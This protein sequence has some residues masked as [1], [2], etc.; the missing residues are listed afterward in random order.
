MKNIGL[1][2]V[3]GAISLSVCLASACS[4]QKSFY[5]Q[6]SG[7]DYLRFPLLEPYYAIYVTNEY[8][9]SI[10]LHGKPTTRNF[11]YYLNIQDVRKIAVEN[12]VIMIYTPYT[13]QIDL[14]D[15]QKRELHWFI[16][17][18]DQIELGFGKEEDFK[19]K[20]QQYDINEPAW[21]DP[22]TILLKFDQTGC[23]DWIPD[24]Q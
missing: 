12:G 13:K 23:L 16:L 10:P 15:G 18:P 1:F 7:L 9:W 4:V 20:I 14:G 24:C 6:G 17:V 19:N 3:L 11:L 5:Q 2:L 21:Q 22:K 8:G